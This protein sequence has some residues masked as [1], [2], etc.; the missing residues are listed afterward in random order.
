VLDTQPWVSPRAVS[1]RPFGADAEPA[2]NLACLRN[3]NHRQRD[4]H[5]SWEAPLFE[6]G[7]LTDHEPGVRGDEERRRGRRSPGQVGM[8]RRQG[9]R[10]ASWSAAA[11]TPLMEAMTRGGLWKG[12]IELKDD[13]LLI[14]VRRR[15]RGDKDSDRCVGLPG[16][17]CLGRPRT[18]VDRRGRKKCCHPSVHFGHLPSEA[19][20]VLRRT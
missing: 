10:W 16:F 11:V 19:S 20:C 13:M 1:C 14:R 6:I 12:T 7:L 9:E 17:R 8:S 4:R 3:G 2:L 15:V 5:G 18:G